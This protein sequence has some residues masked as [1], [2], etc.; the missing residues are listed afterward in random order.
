MIA[1]HPVEWLEYRNFRNHIGPMAGITAKYRMRNDPQG[2]VLQ[3]GRWRAIIASDS[4]VVT[5][6][7]V[8]C[9]QVT[10]PSTSFD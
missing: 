6:P 8:A 2:P 10:Y 3:V 5:V 4:P 9:S 7:V 1:R